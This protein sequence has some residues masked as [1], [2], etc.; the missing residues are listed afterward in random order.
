MARPLRVQF[1]GAVYYVMA[2][3]HERGTLFRDDKDREKFVALLAATARDEGWEVHAYCL[4]GNRYHLLVETPL[5]DL[6]RGMHS[7]N[8]RYSQWFNR[9]H[10][11]SG[12]VLEGR[13]KA[14]LV[15]K[16]RHLLELV[17]Y[18][19]LSPVRAGLA[20]RVGDWRWSSYPATAGRRDPPEWLKVDWTLE[21]F[22]RRRSAAREAYR[23]F[24]AKGRGSG[25]DVEELLRNPYI[26]D[27]EFG[28][29]IQAMLDG[30]PVKDEIPRRFRR[31]MQT[32]LDAVRK[33]V[34]KEWDV[35]PEALSRS[36]GGADKK[37][38]IYLARKL[39]RLNGR[40]IGEAFGIKPARVSNVV[41][42]I[43]SGESPALLRRVERLRMRMERRE[44]SQSV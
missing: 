14:V 32:E 13:F 22:A 31:A 40:E 9:R 17:R 5:G 15:Q 24:V 23:R 18:V 19:V 29:R 28:K 16:R 1:P 21:Q 8:G 33:A 10:E 37:A 35:A 2:R 43:E 30:K 6:S 26:G 44:S 20:A 27:R 34:A 25:E 41:T 7:I 3:V 39:T 12:H 36:R 4:M 42:Q 11:R 38:A